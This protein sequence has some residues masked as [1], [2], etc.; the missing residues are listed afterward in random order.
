MSFSDGTPVPMD[1]KVHVD[2]SNPMHS[3]Q[4]RQRWNPPSVLELLWGGNTA[5]VG[6]LSD[7]TILKFPPEKDDR[8]TWKC[9]EI[10]HHI[11]SALGERKG[12]VQ[13]LGKHEHG[14]R[15]RRAKNGD[16]KH[17]LSQ[18]EPS[19]ISLRMRQKWSWQAAD[20]L[21]YVHSKGVIHCDIHPNNFLLD[22][23]LDLQLCDFSGSCFGEL[24]GK[25]MESTR[26]FLPRDP[27]STPNV[28]TDLFALGS[29]LYCIM[30][31]HQPFDNLPDEEVTLRYSQGDFPDVSAF[32]C[33]R[34]IKA[35]WT[36][37]FTN[38]HEVA[39][40]ILEDSSLDAQ[41]KGDTIPDARDEG[42]FIPDA[43][44][45]SNSIL[46]AQAKSGSILDAQDKSDS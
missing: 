20:I 14:L 42:I 12:L 18:H 32:K 15:F 1:G 44:D 28:R 10:E 16:L 3:Y 4:Y 36:G 40:A 37:N 41:V 24:D 25:A 45:K 11:L 21:G 26:F 19:A 31:R 2:P 30:S 39:Q 27:L 8:W 17:Y 46:D 22:E 33:G 34:A 35:C 6:L 23:H 43:Q 38:A 7:G 13:Y 9:L 29:L 5:S